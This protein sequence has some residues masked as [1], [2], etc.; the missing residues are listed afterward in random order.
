MKEARAGG[1][2]L[3]LAERSLRHESHFPQVSLEGV[4]GKG[5]G[6]WR[7]GE[8]GGATRALQAATL[9]LLLSILASNARTF[10][11]FD[12][13]P[14][15]VGGV[16]HPYESPTKQS[17]NTKKSRRKKQQGQGR[18]QVQRSDRVSIN[19]NPA[20]GGGPGGGSH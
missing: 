1:C 15:G 19:D 8:G 18:P 11:R 14:V 2:E 5:G 10:T 16:W 9:F 20:R 3:G 13:Q 6:A 4:L 7:R 12:A 17:R